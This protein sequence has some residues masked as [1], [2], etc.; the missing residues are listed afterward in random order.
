MSAVS[1]LRAPRR[2]VNV[3]SLLRTKP[4]RTSRPDM[5]R[6]LL[7]ALMGAFALA[8]CASAPSLPFFAE[9][10]EPGEFAVAAAHPLATEAGMKIIAQG[11]SAVDAA[12]AVQLVLTLVEP[13]SSGVGGGA[14]ML[15]YDASKKKLSGFDG[16]EIA[17]ATTPADLFL[18]ETG[19]PL[20]FLDAVVGGRSVGAPG[21]MAMLAD[22]HA[23]H[24]QLDWPALTAPALELAEN[25]FEITPR[26][27]GLIA[28]IPRLNQLPTAR[29]YFYDAD[30]A[31]LPV[32][33]LLKNPDYAET[34]RILAE[35]G[36]EAFYTGPVAEAIVEAVQTT[37][38]SPGLLTME[39]LA[40]YEPLRKEPICIPYR[41]YTVCGMPPSTSGGVA[42]L[43]TLGILQSFDIAAMDPESAEPWA[44]FI[45]ALKLAYADRNAYIGDPA[46]VD[47]PTELLI[48]P[49]YLAHR[50]ELLE[51]AA[52][53]KEGPAGDPYA[54]FDAPRPSLAGDTSPK[55][56]STTHFSIIDP[57][58][59][60]ISMTSSV[61]FAFGSH[62]MAGGFILNNQLTDFS[63][64]PEKDGKP[65]ANAVG[66]GKRP[67]SSM[68]PMV[69]LDENGELYALVG[70]PGGGAIIAYVAKTLMA[71][72]DWDMPMQDAIESANIVLGRSGAPTAEEGRMDPALLEGLAEIGHEMGARALTSG[73]HGLVITAEGIDAGA[74]SRREGSYRISS[75]AEMS[76]VGEEVDPCR[77]EEGEENGL[78]S[79]PLASFDAETTPP[80]GWRIWAERKCYSEAA[81]LIDGYVK[82]QEGVLDAAA[83][84]D[85]TA[86]AEAL[87][88]QATP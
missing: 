25:G 76:A 30:G 81:S 63:F 27:A 28:R 52:A 62:L 24:G 61:E 6:I 16:R 82:K 13:Q 4:P 47:V 67:R 10:P 57:H 42:V 66:P 83:I 34:L 71:V 1:R 65:V 17:P 80:M 85:L 15:H 5:T 7:S 39:D 33:T 77:I 2:L 19:E 58:G 50:A 56:P 68:S 75:G 3:N 31:P 51:P 59:D 9:D 55:A 8:G 88:A 37:E 78:L 12:I 49:R 54:F 73:L 22:A 44:L 23:D 36:P 72:L 29:A 46:I 84:A 70:S 48:D 87:R 45:D 69:V 41:T 20:A 60:A 38:I 53:L 64:R 40:A 26:M 35:Q 79:L 11:G 14:Y 86:Q 21:V 32:G 43:Q 18:D 74:D